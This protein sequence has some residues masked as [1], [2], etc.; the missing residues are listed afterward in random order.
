[1]TTQLAW[2]VVPDSPGIQFRLV[3]LGEPLS[4]CK[5]LHP[6][7]Q[8]EDN[9]H[10]QECFE[11]HINHSEHTVPTASP[12]CGRAIYG[13]HTTDHPG[14]SHWRAEM[15]RSPGPEYITSGL[16]VIEH[17]LYW[18]PVNN[19]ISLGRDKNVERGCFCCP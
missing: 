13:A 18:R 2:A 10:L 16:N 12:F 15:L 4:H 11:N 7:L 3:T 6:H 8:S 17:C 5:P 14:S 19:G 9:T 1:M